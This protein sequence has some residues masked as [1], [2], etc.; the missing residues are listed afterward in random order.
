MFYAEKRIMDATGELD[1]SGNPTID[2]LANP[3][4]RHHGGTSTAHF[5]S[6][7]GPLFPHDPSPADIKQQALADC[8][9]LAAVLAILARPGGDRVV[10]G[11]LK[12]RG[13]RVVVRLYDTAGV[14]RYVSVEKS[15]RRN[16]E[17]HNGGALWATMIEKAYAA[18][19]FVEENKR[20]DGKPEAQPLR[21][22]A[23]LD[24]GY[25]RIAMKVLLG[26]DSDKYDLSVGTFEGTDSNLLLGLW[27]VNE[28]DR[29]EQH[30]LEQMRIKIFGGNAHARDRFLQ[31]RTVHVKRQWEVLLD[32][33]GDIKDSKDSKDST[34]RRRVMRLEDF[35]EFLQ[36]NGL[37]PD[38]AALLVAFVEQNQLLAGRRGTGVYTSKMLKAFDRIKGYVRENKPV[39]LTTTKLVASVTSGKGKSGGEAIGKGLAGGHVYAVVS[40]R[41]D[42][43]APFRKWIRIRNPW[44]ET[45][46]SY[47]PTIPG[48]NVLKAQAIDA[49]EFDLELSDLGKRFVAMDFGK[50]A[51]PVLIDL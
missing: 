31:W 46:R 6:V 24:T 16:E 29:V 19:T 7:A 4:S 11:M 12:E 51:I 34:V 25:P 35:T 41:E 47:V 22:Y 27:S 28:L 42:T 23:K 5:T 33:H 49:G 17:K 40:V 9:L 38:V 3:G 37:A 30:R 44:G 48:S 1:L 43:A 39:A 14:A 10:A 15:I 21:G 20:P 13:G 18:A 36:A 45:G 32:A 26:G 50:G 2:V 8:Y